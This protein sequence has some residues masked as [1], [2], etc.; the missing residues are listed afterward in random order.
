MLF[1]D[2]NVNVSEL[3]TAKKGCNLCDLI[4]HTV[5]RYN[6]NGRDVKI[7]R[8][9]SVLTMQHNGK[10]I[11]RLCTDLGEYHRRRGLLISFLRVLG[12]I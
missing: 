4:L 3:C 5:E 10:R 2:D 1:S 7:V 11:L 12:K 8:I 9:G 6:G